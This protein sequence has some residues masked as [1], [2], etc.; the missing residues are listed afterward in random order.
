MQFALMDGSGK[1]L[2]IRARMKHALK[3]RGMVIKK[4]GMIGNVMK[5]VMWLVS[6]DV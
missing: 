4:A 1:N 3:F 2:I 5:N 6:I